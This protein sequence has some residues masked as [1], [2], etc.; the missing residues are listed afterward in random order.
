[1]QLDEKKRKKKRE[2]FAV[3]PG[4]DVDAQK[5]ETFTKNKIDRKT[6]KLL[7][8]GAQQA[9]DLEDPVRL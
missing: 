2:N 8:F 1:M 5:R 9:N 4:P 3:R 7:V 6:A